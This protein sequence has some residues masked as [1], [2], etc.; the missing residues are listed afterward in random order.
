MID[1]KLK[2][3]KNAPAAEDV[4]MNSL[5]PMQPGQAEAQEEPGQAEV[6]DEIKPIRK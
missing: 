5:T 2:S 1:V 3:G 6:Q 4:G